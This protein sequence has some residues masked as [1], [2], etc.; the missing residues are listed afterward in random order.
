MNRAQKYIAAGVPAIEI[1][2]GM[3]IY[4]KMIVDTLKEYSK[5]IETKEEIMHVATISANNDKTIGEDDCH[6]S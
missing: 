5:P 3:D 6:G 2:R 1:K 4:L